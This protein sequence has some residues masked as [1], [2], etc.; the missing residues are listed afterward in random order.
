MLTSAA[1]T[2]VW[3]H[4]TAAGTNR[5]LLVAVSMNLRNAT[6]TTVTT[7]TYGGT[8][9]TLLDAITDAAPDTRTEVW[10]LLGGPTGAN[11]VIITMGGITPGENVE[12]VSS[13]TTLSNVD[14]SAPPSAAA[15]GNGTPASVTL[16]GTAATDLVLDFVGA[17]ETVTLTPP[18]TQT[19][20]FNTSTGGTN[21][22]IQAASS[23]RVAAT[24]NTTMTWTLSATRRWSHIAVGVK[25]ATADVEVTQ[26]ALPDP[27]EP[28]GILTYTFHIQNNGPSSA[29]GVTL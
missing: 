18:G 2:T 13:A 10:Y 4:T 24:P 26:S 16:T 19:Q 25:Q 7:V 29:T 5:L 15:V 9:L 3:S 12:S 27:V 14:Q 6:G 21:D 23:G 22:D 20:G 17:R 8:P 28:G 1:P 11:N